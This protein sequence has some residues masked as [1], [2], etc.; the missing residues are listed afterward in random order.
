MKTRFRLGAAIA[1]LGAASAGAQV[2]LV[3]QVPSVDELKRLLQ[4]AAVAPVR[5]RAIE[6]DAGG[7]SAPP[8]PTAAPARAAG[9]AV[10][11]PITFD[12]GSSRLTALSSGYVEVVAQAMLADPTL[13]L[14]IEGHTDAAGH[15]QRNLLLS[16][17]RAVAV[18]R[19]L[20]ERYGIDGQRLHPSGRGPFEPLEGMP[21]TASANR[22][23][24]FRVVQR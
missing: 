6:W 16:W 20:V 4:P 17:D 1:L 18:Y 2:T 15:P 21:P 8:V 23:V 22:R 9:P 19:V 14:T 10:A 5:S 13:Q 3:N 24:Q 11:M 12:A 7:A